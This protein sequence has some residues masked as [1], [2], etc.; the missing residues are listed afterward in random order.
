MLLDGFI[1]TNFFTGSQG[2]RQTVLLKCFS[3]RVILLGPATELSRN[4]S[5]VVSE[6][7]VKLALVSKNTRFLSSGHSFV[8]L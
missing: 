6:L 3:L 7:Q 8:N 5:S 2:R 4:V 1:V